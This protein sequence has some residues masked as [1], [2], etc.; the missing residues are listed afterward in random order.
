LGNLIPFRNSEVSL[1]ETSDGNVKDFVSDVSEKTGM[2]KT[3]IYEYLE[4]GQRI[5]D[6]VGEMIRGTELEDRKKDLLEISR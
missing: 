6:E 5:T 1:N 4:I 3:T 2:S